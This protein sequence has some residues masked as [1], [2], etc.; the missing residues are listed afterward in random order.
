MSENTTQKLSLTQRLGREMRA[1]LVN[2]VFLLAVLIAFVNYRTLALE[3]YDVAALQYGWAVVEAM[4]LGK[5]VLVGEA[6]HLGT[7]FE[8]LPIA[9][10]VLWKTLVFM[11]FVA[12]FM[13]AEHAVKALVHHRSLGEEF[14][15]DRIV[16]LEML[17]RLQLLFVAFLPLFTYRELG[18]VMGQDR[19][20]ALLFRR[21]PAASP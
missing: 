10:S 3:E 21:R 18:R 15:L 12:A 14:G 11:L 4:I 20:D 6:L 17:A 19:L 9:V 8:D 13:V 2:S 5:I 7:R 16:E 1:Y